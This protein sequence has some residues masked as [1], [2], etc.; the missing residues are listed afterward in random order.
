MQAWS[1]VALLTKTKTQIGGFVVRCT[2][3]LSFFLEPGMEL[4]FVPPRIDCPR[5]AR[6]V[7]VDNVRDMTASVMF[8]S[9]ENMQQ[10]LD[11]VGAHCLI[12]ESLMTSEVLD[13]AG[14]RLVGMSVVDDVFG[15]LGTVT[16]IIANP[17]QTLLVVDCPSHGKS[18]VMIPCVEEFILDIDDDEGVIRTSIPSGLLEL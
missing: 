3:G 12:D 6:I 11:L 13:A 16:D 5:S 8:D 1:D 17:G 4:F 15:E 18:D 9:F 10:M 14:I 7:S 2:T